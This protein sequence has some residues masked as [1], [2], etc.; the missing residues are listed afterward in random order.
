[1]TF[2]S[3]VEEV[4]YK[5]LATRRLAGLPHEWDYI[6]GSE[7]VPASGML[8]IQSERR[9]ND[10]EGL[11][12]LRPMLSLHSCC[13]GYLVHGRSVNNADAKQGD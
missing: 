7:S 6:E 8:D 5:L 13:H 9:Y 11:H 2:C 4:W 12:V 1:M 3:K 10:K